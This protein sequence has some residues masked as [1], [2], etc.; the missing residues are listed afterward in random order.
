M[1]LGNSAQLVVQQIV[2]H[3]IELLV[4]ILL[5][6]DL[7]EPLEPLVTVGRRLLELGAGDVAVREGEAHVVPEG[8]VGHVVEEG[9]VV[10]RAL[11]A[12]FARAVVL[13]QPDAVPLVEFRLSFRADAR[14]DSFR[15]EV[16]D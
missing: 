5:L 3:V 4:V 12:H 13:R 6:E 7:V 16:Y 15:S 9:F 2:H 8:V 10:E 11:H 14:F 1:V